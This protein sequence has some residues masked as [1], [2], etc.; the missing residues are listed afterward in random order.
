MQQALRTA[1]SEVTQQYAVS[2]A[3]NWYVAQVQVQKCTKPE[4]LKPI[5]RSRLTLNNAH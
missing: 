1:I 5:V 3:S 4:L 2:E